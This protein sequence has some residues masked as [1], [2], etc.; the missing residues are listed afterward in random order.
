MNN[1]QIKNIIAEQKKK[2]NIINNIAIDWENTKTIVNQII[3]SS[4]KD[5]EEY[6]NACEL[7]N[8]LCEDMKNSLEEIKNTICR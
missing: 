7:A 5:T 2:A 3:N 4:A 8:S 6:K 1:E